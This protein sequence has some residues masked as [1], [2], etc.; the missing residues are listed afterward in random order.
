MVPEEQKTAVKHALEVTFGVS[1][2]ENISLITEGLS[3]ALIFKII[4]LGKPYLLRIITSRDAISDPTHW[5]GCM[6]AAA[7][8]GLAPRVW[9]TGIDDRVSITDFVE[10]KDFPIAVARVK[11]PA[12]L[13]RLHSLPRFPFRIDYL[14]R[15][16]GFVQ[17]F[18]AA[19]IL[20][21]NITNEIFSRYED[22][23]GVYPRNDD[24][25]V[26]CHN[27]LK[28]ENIL[29]DGDRPWLVDWEA[30]FLNDRYMDLSV[31]ANFVVHNDD[32]EKGYLK[33]YF[34]RE[35]MEYEHAR[36]FLMRQ[37]L[38]LFYFTF[39]MM[40]CANAGKTIDVNL[41]R[42]G[43]REFH[44]S[45]WV[46]KINLKND[47]AR[48][49]YSLVHMDQLLHNMQQKRFGESLKIVSDISQTTYLGK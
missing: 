9:Y 45:M 17:K 15:M 5:Y 29:F 46:G 41:P 33:T 13:N 3:T 37:M 8:A 48:L 7:A 36:F 49:L 4:V 25:M 31:V 34:G 39:F 2:F 44:D 11:L 40:L 30:A 1:E 23:K 18:R 32:D 42:P 14:D 20:P 24:D 16:D 27:D 21:E 43:F 28:P 6:T 12:L 10:K 19:K 22:I 35:A 26:A 38:H 47:D